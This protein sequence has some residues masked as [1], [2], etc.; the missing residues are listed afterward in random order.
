MTRGSIAPMVLVILDGWGYRE[1]V[2]GNA[3]AAAK[4]P[5]VDSLWAAYPHT[6]IRTSG[7]AVGLP[8]GQMGNSE[9]GHLNIGAGR[10]VPQELVRISDAVED[11]TL[12]E[13]AALLEVC[14]EVRYR[15]SK[16]HLIGLCSEGGVHSHLEHLLGLL[17]MARSQDLESVCIHIITDGRDTKPTD[18]QFAVQKLQNYVQQNEFGRLVTLSGRYYAMDRDRR[19]ER[20]E[21]VYRVM[22]EDGEGLGKSALDALLD[23]Y[24]HDITDEFVE[25]VR[26]APGAVEAGDGIVFFNFRPDRARQLTQAFLDP[27]FN[28]FERSPLQPLSFATMTQYDPS[29]PVKVAFEPQNLTNILGQVIAE[30]GLKQFRTAETEK[31]AHVTYFFNGGLEDPFPGEDRELIPSPMVATYDRAPEMSARLVTDAAIAAIEKGIYSLIVI[32][33]ANPDMV[34]HTGQIEATV[35]ALEAVDNEVGRLIER[36]NRSG[37]SA[38]IIADH[39][40]AEY[41]RDENGKPWTA[42][43][44]NPVPFILVEGEKLKLSGYGTDVPLREDGRLSDIAPTI[45]QVLGIPQPIEMTGRSMFLPASVEFRPN[46]TPVRLSR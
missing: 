45:L 11:G 1:D 40:N 36:V 15:G 25:P 2:S 6:L 37:G 42:H 30:H 10:I 3:I 32:N 8:E 9:V 12:Q 17:D 29:F 39:G 27:N 46:R 20:V 24:A 18:G 28:G 5:V 38:I 26:L 21:K 19:W 4:T 33:Y 13:N 34:G 41:M 44:T 31:Y 7:K 22:T 35:A 23:S 16:L 43:T 14:Q